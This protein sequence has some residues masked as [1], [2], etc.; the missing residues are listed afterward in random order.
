MENSILDFIQNTFKDAQTINLEKVGQYLKQEDLKVH[1][2]GENN[3]QTFL[4]NKF[5]TKGEFISNCISIFF[6]FFYL[7]NGFSYFRYGIFTFDQEG[8]IAG[9]L[10]RRVQKVFERLL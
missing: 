1:L 9:R 7:L 5:T 3:W 2:A 8:K 4:K 10:F 6:R